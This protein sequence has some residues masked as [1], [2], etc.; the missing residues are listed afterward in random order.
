[1]IQSLQIATLDILQNQNGMCRNTFAEQSLV[2][3]AVLL[4]V[5][6]IEGTIAG[7]CAVGSSAFLKWRF[8][9]N[10]TH[11]HCTTT[12]AITVGVEFTVLAKVTHL[13]WNNIHCH[14]SYL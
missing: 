5:E 8:Y 6:W 11:T 9:S 13:Y 7:L 1:M 14:L 2:S 10:G 4:V 12:A 3:R